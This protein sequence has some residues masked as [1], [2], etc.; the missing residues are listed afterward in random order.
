MDPVN[1]E[2]ADKI[3][4]RKGYQQWKELDER[5]HYT[6]EQ[7]DAIYD[8]IDDRNGWGSITQADYA[9]ENLTQYVYDRG[10]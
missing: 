1:H 4:K 2:N 5:V 7:L 8:F 9:W 6:A 3:R 10:E